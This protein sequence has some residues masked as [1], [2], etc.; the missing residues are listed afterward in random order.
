MDIIY[1]NETCPIG[2]AAREKFLN[3]NNSAYD[4]FIDFKLFA[5]KC[6]KACPC[7]EVHKELK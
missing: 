5:D 4:A 3:E 2:R 1:C 6:F 7:K